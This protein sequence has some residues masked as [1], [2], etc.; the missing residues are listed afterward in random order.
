MADVEDGDAAADDE[1]EAI[2]GD[3][4]ATGAGEAAGSGAT[5]AGLSLS[6]DTVQGLPDRSKVNVL[7]VRSNTSKGPS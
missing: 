2:A 6:T 1:G 7:G 5:K 4:S 3:V